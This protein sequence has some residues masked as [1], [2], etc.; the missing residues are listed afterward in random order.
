MSIT[1]E[2]KGHPYC[3]CH[4]NSFATSAVLIKTEIPSFC[5]NQE[6]STPHNL[7]KEVNISVPSRTL[8]LTLEVVNGDICFL[9]R[10]RLEPK[11]LLWQ[12]Q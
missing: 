7:L 6:P 9:D 5:L 12:Q 1:K 4:D 10:K 8:C 2:A 3:C 11:E